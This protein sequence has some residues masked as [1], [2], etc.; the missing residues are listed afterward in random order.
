MVRASREAVSVAR[1]LT[2]MWALL[3]AVLLDDWCS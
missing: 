1:L 2:F 3:C